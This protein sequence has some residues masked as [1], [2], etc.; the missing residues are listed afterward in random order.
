MHGRTYEPEI[1]LYFYRARYLHPELGRFLQS[2]P[3]GYEDSLNMYQAFNQNPV[4]FVDP[5]GEDVWGACAKSYGAL[6]RPTENKDIIKKQWRA[7]KLFF[8]G[9]SNA[10]IQTFLLP[11]KYMTLPFRI[12]FG[13]DFNVGVNF[14]GDGSILQGEVGKKNRLDIVKE[15]T[16]VLPLIGS[17]KQVRED[18]K[19]GNLDNILRTGGSF[20]FNALF[21]GSV[22][23]LGPTR[24]QDTFLIRNRVLKNIEES[25]KARASSNFLEYAKWDDIYQSVEKLDFS[26]SPDKAVFYSGPGNKKLALDFA[27]RYDATPINYTFGGKYLES[28]DVYSNF[29]SRRADLIMLRASEKY[30]S[31]VSGKITLFVKGSLPNRVF[32]SVEEPILKLNINVT[33]WQFMG[34]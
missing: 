33:K 21:W 30:T 8:E 23:K 29:S 2:D 31:G 6:L 16:V 18:I 20:Y 17:V 26:T 28:L 7:Y 9:I 10:A 25:R 3:N 24:G 4:N 22:Y 34:Y 13:F 12:A 19:S 27:N 11:A 1:G 14:T 32:R 5:F 15:Q